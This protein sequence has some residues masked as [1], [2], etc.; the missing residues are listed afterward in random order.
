MRKQIKS[1]IEANATDNA[2][3]L[4]IEAVAEKFALEFLYFVQGN[5]TKT[6][7]TYDLKE[8]PYW[9]FK[10]KNVSDVLKV[11]K[12]NKEKLDK[13]NLCSKFIKNENS[14][15]EKFCCN[16]GRERWVH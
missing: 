2:K 6:F 4:E 10:G 3:V 13:N 5:Y 15:S 7:D 11:F 1:W 9:D 16:C 8:R 14:L 12:E